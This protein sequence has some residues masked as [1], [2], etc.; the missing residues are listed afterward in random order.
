MKLCCSLPVSVARVVALMTCSSLAYAQMPTPGVALR[1]QPGVPMQ[2]ASVEIGLHIVVVEGQNGVNII[3]KR[4]AVR[5]V[6]QVRDR[7]NMPVAGAS[8]TFTAPNDDPSAIF[9]NGSRSETMVTDH[10]GEATVG[11]MRPEG[12][13]TF[14]LRVT[15]S[16]QGDT[17]TATI[18]Q[19]NVTTAAEAARTGA[20]G[21]QVAT[22]ATSG[23]SHRTVIWI[24]AGAVVAAGAG[25]GV[26]LANG[27]SSSASGSVSVGTPTVGAPH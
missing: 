13:G 22:S 9:L 4:A 16:F 5:P 18:T 15:A 12:A 25:A 24:V 3:K 2:D 1:P 6:V 26:A 21:G 20:A 27:K 7:T 11:S 8:V 23:V 17:A 14:P 10:S 19:T